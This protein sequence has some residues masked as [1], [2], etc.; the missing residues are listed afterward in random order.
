MKRCQAEAQFPLLAR[1]A[2]SSPW[3]SLVMLCQPQGLL[4]DVTLPC[5]RGMLKLL[6]TGG[7]PGKEVFWECHKLFL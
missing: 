2:K 1:V 3:H 4:Q 7:S 5:H 6:E